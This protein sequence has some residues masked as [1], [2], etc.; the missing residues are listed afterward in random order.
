MSRTQLNTLA[1]G[2][3]TV[4]LRNTRDAGDQEIITSHHDMSTT[5]ETVQMLL[6]NGTPDWVK[7]PK[8]FK[9]YAREAMAREKEISDEMV[10]RYQMDDQI[11]LTNAP[12]RLINRMGTEDFIEKLRDN[13]ICPVKCFTVYNGLPGTVGLWCLPPKITQKA[14]YVCYLRTPY[15]HEWSL[16]KVD[17]HNLPAGELRGW[18]TVIVELI[19]SEILTEWQADQ[20]F[21]KASERKVYRRYHQSLWEIRHGKRLTP[22]E[23]ALKEA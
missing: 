19:K 4:D 1:P 12:A 20:I 16:L 11:D 7:R 6:A 22:E 5:D 8:D 23:L 18:R 14:R 9:N 17:S 15:M 13:P 10:E 3:S 21:G 2:Q